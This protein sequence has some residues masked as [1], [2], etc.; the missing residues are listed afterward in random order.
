M[1]IGEVLERRTSRH[2]PLDYGHLPPGNADRLEVRSREAARRRGGFGV[3][4]KV[5]DT[6]GD[7]PR[8]MKL[9]L[10]DRHSHPRDG[11]R[12]N[13]RRCCAFPSIPTW[14]ECIDA[15]FSEP[16]TC[17]PTS[18]SSSSTARTSGDGP[19]PLFSPEDAL[20]LA[21]QVTDGLVHLHRHG[22]YHC[23]IKPRNLLWTRDGV[24]DHRLQRLG[25]RG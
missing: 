15:Q 14:C 25:K 19:Q 2:P 11:S 7:V 10:T 9:I 17:R 3:V 16:G 5:I 1:A 8:A 4:Y 22:V 20:D 13:T 12:R 24:Q 23:D 6:L 18:S 21:R